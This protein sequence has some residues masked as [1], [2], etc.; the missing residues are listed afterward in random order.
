[1]MRSHISIF[2]LQDI[3]RQ[4]DINVNFVDMRTHHPYFVSKISHGC[5]KKNKAQL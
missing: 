5:K 2:N 3:F 4:P 1:M